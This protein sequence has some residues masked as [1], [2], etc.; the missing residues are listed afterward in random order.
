MVGGLE[1]F[2]IYIFRNP[3]V[4]G[5]TFEQI[6]L[7]NMYS[8]KEKEEFFGYNELSR[9]VFLTNFLNNKE[10]KGDIK[11]QALAIEILYACSK[12]NHNYYKKKKRVEKIKIRN[13]YTYPFIA[14]RLKQYSD[15]TNID[16]EKQTLKSNIVYKEFYTLYNFIKY[17]QNKKC[18]EVF[19]SIDDSK[20]EAGSLLYKTFKNKIIAFLYYKILN[21]IITHKKVYTIENIIERYS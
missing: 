18:Y 5:K 1:H 7:G 2:D 16:L 3:V 17:I 12:A 20:N 11:E 13:E 14:K 10:C 21:Y 4:G 8:E 19:I 15:K 6:H 9:E